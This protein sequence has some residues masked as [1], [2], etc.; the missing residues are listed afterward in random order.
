M[1]NL[2]N[3]IFR[4]NHSYN[5]T[6]GEVG[7]FTVRQLLERCQQGSGCTIGGMDQ[8]SWQRWQCLEPGLLVVLAVVAVSPELGLLAAVM[9]Q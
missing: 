3:Q 2:S 7:L 5:Q 6:T 8:N 4:Q 1:V 9:P